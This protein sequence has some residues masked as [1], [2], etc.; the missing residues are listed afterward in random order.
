MQCW[1][2]I[3]LHVYRRALNCDKVSFDGGA[4]GKCV[5][6]LS[7][8]VHDVIIMSWHAILEQALTGIGQIHHRL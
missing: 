8:I 4:M 1:L 2:H 5:L 6:T 3:G 7:C